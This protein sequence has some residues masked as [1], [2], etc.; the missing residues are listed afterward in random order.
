MARK[1]Y[2]YLREADGTPLKNAVILFYLNRIVTTPEPSIISNLACSAK[3]NGEGYFE[4]NLIPNEETDDPNSYYTMRVPQ[5][6][7]V[8]DEF[9]FLQI[10]SGTTPID[11]RTCIL[12]APLTEVPALHRLLS[13]IHN[14]VAPADVQRG[15]IIAG[16]QI[17]A[18]IKWALKALGAAGQV[19]KSN[20]A[21]ITWG[22]VVWEE[23][24]NKPSAFPHIIAKAGTD[25]GTRRRINF[26][27]GA[28]I[29]ITATDNAT[30]DRVDVTI[31]ATG[32]GGGSTVHNLLSDT[33]SDTNPA[34][35]ARGSIISGQLMADNTIKWASLALGTAGQV[36]KSNGTDIL[37]GNIDWTEVTNKP[38]AFPIN[39]QK[40]GTTI[41]T[42]P[43]VNFIEGSNVTITVADNTANNRVD[44]TIAAAGAGGSSEHSLLSAT[45]N[46]TNP[47]SV[48][49]GAIISGQLMADNTIKW[50][51]LALGT[52]GQVLKSNGTD[53]LWSN[54][55]WTE[56]T[57]KPSAFPINVQKAGATTGT[58][59]TIN[60][61]EG[62]NVTIT[63]ADDTA[64]NR[65]N[66]TIAATGT[67][68]GTLVGNVSG[69]ATTPGMG[70]TGW[71]NIYV[72]Y[73]STNDHTLSIYAAGVSADI[74]FGSWQVG[75]YNASN[76]IWEW[77]TS[78]VY[79]SGNP[80]TT[81]TLTSGYTYYI[82]I[83][84]VGPGSF[85]VW[86]FLSFT[87]T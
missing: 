64:N 75:V 30:N 34:S 17:G 18:S 87:Y 67:G 15:A 47:A 66:V 58:R 29:T 74:P 86:G 69:S 68:G 78:A 27:E 81:I 40:V 28:N 22:S 85:T 76:A 10:P 6:L 38:S 5:R 11:F 13:G 55:D 7:G 37:W 31:A 12:S 8:Q 61:I 36:L 9:I 4:V 42:R 57:N 39:V 73:D 48:T 43:T 79:T 82:R 51:L 19:L 21:D 70:Q 46:D 14:D 3:T 56:I 53:I 44:V 59:P 20:G 41:G 2:G 72:F 49:R 84:A 1:V 80:I 60:F 62:S 33:H 26:I 50:A 77:S 54:V 25:V 16:Q 45:H 23:I 65:V 71:S 83:E 32:A 24:T 52:A 63:T 35:V